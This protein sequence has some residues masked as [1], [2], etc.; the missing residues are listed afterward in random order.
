MEEL[1]L[2]S[3]SP[4]RK[5]L[6]TLAGIPFTIETAEVEET[7]EASW[8]PA[9]VVLHLSAL[10]ARAVSAR[11]PGRTVLGA[12][13]I[14][15]LDGE[16]LG[17]PADREDAFRMLRT[18]SGRTHEVYTGVCITDGTKE[19]RFFE[20]TEVTFFDLTDEEIRAYVATGEPLDK[21]GA[22]GIQGRGIVLVKSVTGDFPNVIGL[23]V[24][25]VKKRLASGFFH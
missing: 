6:L 14:V 18:L 11:H 4:R 10:K 23:P 22:Y 17:K 5:E 8:T 2:A 19:D 13:T 25:V 7:F 24:G 3:G 16:I 21:A 20:R 15:A 1:I 12:D 9:E